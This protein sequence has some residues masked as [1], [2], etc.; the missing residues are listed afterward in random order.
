MFR[1]IGLKHTAEMY[2][3]WL[4]NVNEDTNNFWQRMNNVNFNLD[5]L[6]WKDIVWAMQNITLKKF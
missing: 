6:Y 4:S 5:G 1:P 2:R 3:L